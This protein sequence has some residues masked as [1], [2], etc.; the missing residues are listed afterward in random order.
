MHLFCNKM[1]FFIF[2]FCNE[3]RF[4]KIQKKFDHSKNA[5]ILTHNAKFWVQRLTKK[6]GVLTK[7][8]NKAPLDDSLEIKISLFMQSWCRLL[9]FLRN[10]T[11]RC[12]VDKRNKISFHV[13]KFRYKTQNFAT[14]PKILS[15]NAKF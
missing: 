7:V 10:F 1:Q 13:A 9:I 3:M 2:E 14:S 15:Q 12:Y 4:F 6:Y 11:T 8:L 5:K